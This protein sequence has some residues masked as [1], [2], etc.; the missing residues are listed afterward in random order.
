MTMRKTILAAAFAISA[1]GAG[2][3]IAA[4]MNIIQERQACMKAQGKMMG[5]LVLIMKGEKPFDAAAVKT[6]SEIPAAAC[7]NWDKF[8]SE[9]SKPGSEMAKATETWAKEEIWTDPE[10]FKKAGM[11]VYAHEQ[12][13]FK[14]ADDAGFKA[15]FKELA[16]CKGC[17]EKFRRP[18]EG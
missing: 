15:A 10:G 16:G 14:A 9:D 1:L 17:H 2:A 12:A 7:A 11:D 3:V 6:A 4:D 5:E 18:K 13:M 8:W